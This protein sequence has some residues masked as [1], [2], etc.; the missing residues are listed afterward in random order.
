MPEAVA[1]Q[2]EE[3]LERLR[4]LLREMGRLVVAYSGGVDSSLLLHLATRELGGDVLGVMAVSALIPADEVAAAL[5][6]ARRMGW[7]VVP[8]LTAELD[9]E[10]FAANGPDRCYHCKRHRYAAL[11]DLA[12]AS[13]YRHVADGANAD[14]GRDFR[15]GLGAAR[16]LGVRSPLLEVGLTK[17]E[18]RLLAR[19]YG[20][21]N[22]DRPP[23][24]CLATRI[25]YGTPITSGALAQ[26]EAAE[27][28]L[29]RLGLAPCR[30]RH[31]GVCAR[32]EVPED[33]FR[34]VLAPGPRE[35][36][37]SGLRRLGFTYVT[38][39]LQGYR[40][41]SMNDL[42]GGEVRGWTGTGC[43]ASWPPSGTGN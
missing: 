15:P 23:A 29:K 34:D 1:E 27:H 39:D 20:L 28:L 5:E 41:G 22:W 21:P 12:A 35:Q 43:F 36:V 40:P 2:T 3:K 32:I 11:L 19:R 17:A 30:V 4:P 13:G 38:L 10:A 25:P 26:V 42:L 6:L 8:V 7:Q 37:T 18:V 31:H 24:S 33:L 9:V 14:D 16:E